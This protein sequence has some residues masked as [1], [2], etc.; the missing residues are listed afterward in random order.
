[1]SFKVNQLLSIVAATSLGLLGAGQALAATA[2]SGQGNITVSPTS[3][4]TGSTNLFSFRFRTPN[5]NFAAGSQATI[6][7]PANWTAPQTN[8]ASGP[9]FVSVAPVLSASTAS[10]YSIG[11][12]GPWTVTINFSTSQKQGGFNLDYN[13]AVAPATAGIYKFTAQNKQSGGVLKALK[14]G[15]PLVTVNNPVLTNTTTSLTSGP[16]PSTYGDWVTFTATVTGA[17]SGS[18][19]GTITF[20]NGDEVMHTV[21]LDVQGRATFSTNRFSVSDSPC[22]ITAEYSGD[23]SHNG[24]VSAI[25]LQEVNPAVL[26]LSG[27]TASSKV[28]DGV[29]GALLNPGNVSLGGVLAGDDVTLDTAGATASFAGA[30]AGAQKAVNVA[31]LALSGPDS[32]N[33]TLAPAATVFADIIP[34]PLTVTA[35]DTNRIFGAANPPFTASYSGFVA[36][37]NSTVLSGVPAFSTMAN[38]TSPVA[39]NPYPILVTNGTLAAA[40]YSFV[41]VPGQLT[42]TPGPVQPQRIISLTKLSDGNV[43][44]A[45]AGAAGQTYLVQAAS[46]LSADAWQTIATNTTD[47]NGWMTCVDSTATNF[48]SRF[49]RTALP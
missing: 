37:E 32:E 2:K 11:G 7:I 24:S 18:L 9:G 14:S 42:I 20:K 12:S 30:N 21:P 17:D 47:L 38:A 4:N 29:T 43:A 6:L 5:H 25:L 49:Y 8:D 31:G 15:S 48:P 26:T 1:M 36:G 23:L 3:V 10:L 16:N 39:G 45:C 33:Y 27:L 28:Y 35:N 13:R 22:W 46:Q 41:F 34:A 40:N 19:N 44:I